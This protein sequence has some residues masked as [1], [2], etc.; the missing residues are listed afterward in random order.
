[1]VS[2]KGSSETTNWVNFHV[3]N[4]GGIY[5][6][7]FSNMQTLHFLNGQNHA[8]QA[9][10]FVSTWWKLLIAW[11]LQILSEIQTLHVS[12]EQNHLI[13][14]RT[15][16]S[17][18][19]TSTPSRSPGS[20]PHTMAAHPSPAMWSSDLTHPRASGVTLCRFHALPA[21]SIAWMNT[22]STSSA[23]WR[24]TCLASVNPANPP[25]LPLPRNLCLSSTTK[26][27]VSFSVFRFLSHLLVS[28]P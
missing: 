14:R 26:T 11:F 12:H 22:R 8:I 3:V 27:L 6:V 4:A 10:T 13:H 19:S 16:W 15:S 24:R 2:L 20:L 17:P 5:F 25:W 23:S 1:M 7:N 9:L 21:Q 18:T 28:F